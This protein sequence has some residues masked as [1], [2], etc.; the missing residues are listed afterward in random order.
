MNND[1][2]YQLEYQIRV[3]EFS[4]NLLLIALNFTWVIK[5]N[6]LQYHAKDIFQKQLKDSKH[7]YN[8][9]TNRENKFRSCC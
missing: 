8:K 4:M 2:V 6:W 3:I 9:K 5:W 7:V 1:P